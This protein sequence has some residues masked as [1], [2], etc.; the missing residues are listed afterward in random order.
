MPRGVYERKQGKSRS[1]ITPE[2]RAQMV[3]DRAAGMTFPEMSKKYDLHRTTIAVA[4]K[5][6]SGATP[7]APKPASKS[8]AKP[9]K[10]GALVPQM[11]ALCAQGLSYREIG[12]KLHVNTVTVGYY[13]GGPGSKKHKPRTKGEST[14]GHSHIDARFLVGFGCAELERT[15]ASIAQR[16]GIPAN[17]LRQ[18][19]SKFLGSSALRS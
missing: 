11:Q 19:F 4:V 3:A 12:E 2:M 18:G 5:K 1:P 10:F 14:N 16:L 7:S 6:A 17:L 8:K 15:L 9:S 13:L